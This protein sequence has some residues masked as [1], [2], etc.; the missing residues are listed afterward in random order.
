MQNKVECATIASV[1]VKINELKGINY[2]FS[3]ASC[4]KT[5]IQN[6]SNMSF[7]LD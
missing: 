5:Y 7:F 2:A 3:C 4:D 6:E 1:N